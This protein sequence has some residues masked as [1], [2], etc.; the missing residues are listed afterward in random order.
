MKRKENV[1][2]KILSVSIA[3]YNVE[4]Y[5]RECLNSFIEKSVLEKCEVI[6]VDDGSTDNTSAVANEYVEKYP[7]TFV[8]IKKENGGWG[9]TLNVGMKRAT[10]K[11]F[12]QL[13]GDDAFDSRYLEEY[14]KRLEQEEADLIVTPYVSF[15]DKTG[16]DIETTVLGMN[17]PRNK[18]IRVEDIS[19]QVDIYMHACTFKTDLLQQN[20]IEVTEHCFY[21]DMEYMLKAIHF[22]ESMIFIDMNVYRYRIAR[23]GQSVS[24]E[25]FR[26][27]HKE[28]LKIVCTLLEYEENNVQCQKKSLF[29][30]SLK[31]MVQ[32]QYYLFLWLKPS[33]ENKKNLID[34][35][36]FIKEQHPQHYDVSARII[37]LLRMFHFVGYRLAAR[38]SAYK[39]VHS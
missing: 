15:D 8:Y 18:E 34:F 28:H 36:K 26:K 13:D 22:C 19:E 20:K 6:I 17:M 14:I 2:K 1:M 25:G 10:G 24:I 31:N 12:K 5:L 23:A 4:K 37:K 30:N 33:K 32:T 21:T 9:S 27:H 39:K 3:A 7:Q 29:T 11:Y 38:Y 16:M 35:E